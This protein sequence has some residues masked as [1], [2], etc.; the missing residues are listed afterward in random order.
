MGSLPA[1]RIPS[2]RSPWIAQ[3]AHR[4]RPIRPPRPGLGL[5]LGVSCRSYPF[6]THLAAAGR[7]ASELSGLHTR[8]GCRRLGISTRTAATWKVPPLGGDAPARREQHP[9]APHLWHLRYADILAGAKAAVASLAKA[10]IIR[11]W[12][13]AF[14]LARFSL[15]A[16]L[17]V[18]FLAAGRPRHILSV[19]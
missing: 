8:R 1:F 2:R 18:S 11:F 15:R 12:R 13:Q 9:D 4:R 7:K 16:T 17:I 6:A 10:T 19:R 3:V 14:R 5:A